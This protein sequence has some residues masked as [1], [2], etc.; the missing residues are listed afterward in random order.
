MAV[1]TVTMREETSGL[2]SRGWTTAIKSTNEV[3]SMQAAPQGDFDGNL[4]VSQK[5]PT[6]A[7]LRKVADLPVLNAHA[8]S[9]PFKSLY[10][11]EREGRRVLVIFIRHFFCGVWFPCSICCAVANS[12]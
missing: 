6:Q 7:E 10:T 11:A 2:L 9:I 5:P 8:E 12:L 1:Q 4:K 3:P